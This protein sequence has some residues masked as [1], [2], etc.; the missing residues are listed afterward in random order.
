M[1]RRAGA[2]APPRLRAPPVCGTRRHRRRRG[3]PRNC[4][5]RSR[6][7]GMTS[8]HRPRWNDTSPLRQKVHPPGVTSRAS[9]PSTRTY[10]SVDRSRSWTASTGFA[11]F[12]RMAH[13][14]GRRPRHASTVACDAAPVPAT[15]DWYGCATFRLT[16]GRRRGVPRRLHRPRRPV[17]RAPA[18]TADDVDRA[19]WILVGHSH[20]DHLWGAERIARNTGATIVGSYEIDPGDGGAGRAR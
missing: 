15:L 6:T 9:Q 17:R 18:C 8:G 19:D 12:T 11:E 1:V 2:S 10:Q 14:R 3:T 7:A 4:G 13:A 20:F 5:R 16:V